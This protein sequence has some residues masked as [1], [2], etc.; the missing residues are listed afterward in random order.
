MI[1]IA[2]YQGISNCHYEMIGYV[3]EYC[4]SKNYTFNV[5]AHTSQWEDFYIKMF[6]NRM[7]SYTSVQDFNPEAYD[8]IFLLTDDDYSFKNEW[9]H[10]Y[11]QNIICIDHDALLRREAKIH[12]CTRPFMNR[13]N[14]SWAIPCFS[15]VRDITHKKELLRDVTRPQIACIG[16]ST[17]T[18]IAK[19]QE[20][21]GSA[22][23]NI[24]LHI[25][26]RQIPWDIKHSL[27]VKCL[28]NVHVYENV[29]TINMINIL[30]KC[31]HALFIPNTT[32]A[33]SKMSGTM[34]LVF[35]TGCIPIYTNEHD[36]GYNKMF[37]S[38]CVYH[39]DE[40]I[41]QNC[42]MDYNTN[43]SKYF[44]NVSKVFQDRNMLIKH[45]NQVFD[46]YINNKKM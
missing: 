33:Y 43:K 19:Y 38:T 22:F 9:L 41:D 28:H 21:I 25:I 46:Y 35:N 7:P 26:A 4:L 12:V 45:R 3:V 30:C 15:I 2:I 8:K 18:T 24:D 27:E 39:V 34:P 14:A 42:I 36:D 37:Q 32:F 17:M 1:N 23:N 13:L 6:G 40:T 11:S 44:D 20:L 5:Y 29:P 16:N 31:T 10:K